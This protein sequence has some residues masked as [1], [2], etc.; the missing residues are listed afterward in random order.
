MERVCYLELYWLEQQEEN[1]PGGV[2]LSGYRWAGYH[3]V[4]MD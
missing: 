4:K 1:V 3:L 2:D